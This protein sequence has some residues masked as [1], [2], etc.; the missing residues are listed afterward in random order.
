MEKAGK[1]DIPDIDKKKLVITYLRFCYSY[2][3]GVA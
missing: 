1:S 3:V 2:I